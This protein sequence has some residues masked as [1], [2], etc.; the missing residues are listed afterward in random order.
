MKTVLLGDVCEFR[1]GLTYKKT[2]EVSSSDNIVLRANNIDPGTFKLNL[3]EMR[4]IR[5]DIQILESK[6][7][8]K[9]SILICTASGS[10][11]HLGKV[12]YIDKDYPYAFGGFMGLLIPKEGVNARYLYK[13]LTTKIFRDYIDELTDGAN[14]NNLRFDLIK[15]FTF[16]L[17]PIDEQKRIVRKLDE[18]FEKIDKAKANT[19]KNLKNA[20]EL[21]EAE[22]EQIFSK[23]KNNWIKKKVGDVFELKPAKAEVRQRLGSND[24]VTFLPMS[25]L[26]SDQKVIKPKK[27]RN[28][29]VVMG[30][31]TY[32]GEEDVLLAKITPCFE[33]GKLGVARNLINGAGFGS[34]EYIVMRSNGIVKPDLLYYFLRR[35]S[36]R[37]SGKKIMTGA[38]GHMRLPAT[39]VENSEIIFPQSTAKQIK[40][41]DQL[42][43]LSAQTK[44]LQELY[45]RKLDALEELRQSLLKLAFE[46]KL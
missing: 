3:S 15:D 33:N 42:D 37:K 39:F 17:P 8:Q 40:L 16:S 28:L 7:L 44:K 32:F 46:G 2:D 9:D 36:F 31:Y 26:P 23:Q 20:Q 30:S 1:R 13:I 5:G 29:R 12:A 45:Q 21:L 27:S 19:E 25:D 14:I 35:K 11:S 38:S 34:S 43:K 22:I 6:K 18:A 4:Y 24:S 10:K 41:V